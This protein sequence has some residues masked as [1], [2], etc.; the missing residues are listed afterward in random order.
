MP[1]QAKLTPETHQQFCDDMEYLHSHWKELRVAY[2]NC[3]VVVYQGQVVA[4]GPNLKKV[5]KALDKQDI[6]SNVVALRFIADPPRK[7][8]L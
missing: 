1:L 8:I 3:Y 6:P 5:I 7:L 4:T 2:P